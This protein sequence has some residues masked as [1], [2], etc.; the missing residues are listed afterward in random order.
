VSRLALYESPNYKLYPMSD[1][2]VKLLKESTVPALDSEAL[3]PWAIEKQRQLQ[4][5]ENLARLNAKYSNKSRLED[6]IPL[7]DN[8]RLK[9]ALEKEAKELGYT[10]DMFKSIDTVSR[11]P[12]ANTPPR[13]SPRVWTDPETGSSLWENP[14]TGEIEYYTP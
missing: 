7:A 6:K 10:K 9:D 11:A 1:N 3:K 12:A 14:D 4:I 13:E 2:D 5:A 8:D